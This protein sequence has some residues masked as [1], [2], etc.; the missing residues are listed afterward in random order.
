MNLS[1]RVDCVNSD[2]RG[3]LPCSDN[4]GKTIK[5]MILKEIEEHWSS[6]KVEKLVRKVSDR[7]HDKPGSLEK[8]PPYYSSVIL[9]NG[10]SNNF[11]QWKKAHTSKR[12][13]VFGTSL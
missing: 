13:K 7:I 9:R 12:I 4:Y 10:G 6:G 3:R 8:R 2:I 5:N 1:T 11:I